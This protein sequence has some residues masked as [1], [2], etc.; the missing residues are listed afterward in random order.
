MRLLGLVVL[1]CLVALPAGARD[2]SKKDATGTD[3]ARG[4]QYYPKPTLGPP[5][6]KGP[7]VLF[8]FDDGPHERLTP[9]IVATLAEHDIKAVFFVSGWRVAGDGATFDKRREALAELLAAGH[10]VG[11]HTLNHAKLC[12]GAADE[13]EREID[14]NAALLKKLTGDDVHWFRTPYGAR[15]KRLHEMLQARGLEHL[16]W[17]MDPHEY[18]HHDPAIVRNYLVHRLSRLEGRGVILL[19]DTQP[20]AARALPNVLEWLVEENERRV[21]SGKLPIRIL[22]PDE[23]KPPPK[24]KR[25]ARKPAGALHEAN[26]AAEA[27]SAPRGWLWRLAPRVRKRLLAPLALGARPTGMR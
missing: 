8:T 1:G 16:G 10:A 26:P 11:N 20:A 13:A 6:G 21:A 22:T 7:A 2:A 14:D 12:V 18:E 15:C 27:G 19:H 5:D 9:L 4:R 25:A 23:V 3:A 17:D 24:K